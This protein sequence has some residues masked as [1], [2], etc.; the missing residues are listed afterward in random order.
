MVTLGVTVVITEIAEVEADAVV[1]EAHGAFDVIITVTTSPLFNE[2]DVNVLFVAPDTFPP[3]ICHW[4]VGVVPPFVG[5]AVN[6]TLVPEQ[7]A[8]PGVP[9]IV[10]L[11]VTVV[12]TEI[13]EVEADAV[14][15]EAHGAFEVMMT[16]TTS[17][18]F[19]E[20]DVNVLFVAPDT[21]PPLICHW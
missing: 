10:T 18:L 6:V 19:N 2:V 5:F 15:G 17:P 21:F 4:Y 14:V 7:I 1:G 16:V 3:L 8:D 9:E 13:A 20:V 11:G 12:I